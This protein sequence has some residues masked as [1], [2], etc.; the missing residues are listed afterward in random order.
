MIQITHIKLN[1]VP[2]RE[3]TRWIKRLLCFPTLICVP[4]VNLVVLAKC[5]T[6][7]AFILPGEPGLMFAAAVREGLSVLLL[8]RQGKPP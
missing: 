8:G 2:Q 3:S 1:A 6:A 4:A 5:P 7:Q